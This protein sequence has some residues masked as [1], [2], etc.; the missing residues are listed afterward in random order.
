MDAK[1]RELYLL[2]RAYEGYE[3]SLLKVTSKNGKTASPV[4]F[5]TFSTQAGAEAAKQDLQQGV[6]FDPDMPQTIRLEFAKSNTKVSKP[7][8]QSPPAAAPHPTL[9]AFTGHL[10]GMVGGRRVGRGDEYLGPPPPPP[11]LLAQ[12]QQCIGHLKLNPAFFPGAPDVWPL[13]PWPTPPS[14]RAQLQ[15]RASSTTQLCSQP[16]TLKSQ[17]VPISD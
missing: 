13:T 4:G 14:C 11:F 1:P 6:R 16:S 5:V 17:Y 10:G 12:L 2:F 15:R 9:V 8:Q 3:G 7:K